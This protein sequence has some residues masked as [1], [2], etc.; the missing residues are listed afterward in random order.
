VQDYLD[1]AERTDGK[2]VGE[3]LD[4]ELS[5]PPDPSLIAAMQV[6][7]QVMTASGV[8]NVTITQFD[9]ATHINTA[10]GRENGFVGE[11][12]IHCWRWSSDADPSLGLNSE[13][14]AP[15]PEIAAEASEAL[16]VAVPFSPTAFSNYWDPEMFGWLAAAVQ[17]DDF[18]ERKALYEQVM[19]RL[20]DQVPVYYSGHTATLIATTDDMV[21][22]NGWTTP[23]G[24]L[25]AGF[26]GA[27]GRWHRVRFTG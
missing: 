1:D 6:F 26:P 18:D 2:A 11:H 16:R 7:E 14:A 20:A 15:T 5:C 3:P 22:L 13:F 23:D 8:V 4:V 9:Q 19:L 12:K 27:E 21:G 25:G 24:T 10:L 17:T